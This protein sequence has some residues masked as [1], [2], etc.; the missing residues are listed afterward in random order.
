MPSGWGLCAHTCPAGAGAHRRRVHQERTG[1]TILTMRSVITGGSSTGE[2]SATFVVTWLQFIL[3][4]YIR[5]GKTRTR[6]SNMRVKKNENIT[7][8]FPQAFAVGVKLTKPSS[9]CV[10]IKVIGSSAQQL[11][12]CSNITKGSTGGEVEHDPSPFLSGRDVSAG[13]VMTN[14]S[15]ALSNDQHEHHGSQL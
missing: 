1:S 14:P 4:L 12:D 10:K 8:S 9:V 6:K 7:P 2:G 11:E 15:H 5:V 3:L 13:Q